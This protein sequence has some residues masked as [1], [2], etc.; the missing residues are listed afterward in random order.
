[1]FEL[2]I[3]MFALAK[4]GVMTAQRYGAMRKYAVLLVMVASAIITPTPDPFN[5]MLVAVPMYALYEIG[6]IL[7]RF[8]RRGESAT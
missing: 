1:M 7:S 6:I 3:F 8:A 2:P 5:M 4:I